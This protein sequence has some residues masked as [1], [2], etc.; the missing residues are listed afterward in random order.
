MPPSPEDRLTDMRDAIAEIEAFLQGSDFD[1]FAADR[2]LRL[3]TER[4]LEIVC[5]AARHLP[6][7]VKAEAKDIDWRAMLDFANRLRHAYQS[8]DSKIV[9]DILQNHLPA[10]KAFVESRFSE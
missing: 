9:W 7:R 4:L 3:I 1:Q 2:G 6:D 10:L 8:T 5:E